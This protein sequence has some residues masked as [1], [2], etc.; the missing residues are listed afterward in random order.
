MKLLL[1][2]MYRG[3]NYCGWQVQENGRTVQGELCRAF[4][5]IV[6]R[7]VK[8]TG[9]SRTDSGV[10]AREYFCTVESED[11]IT[12]PPEKIPLAVNARL[13]RDISVISA[14]KV[15]DA[16]HARYDVK[17]KTYEYIIDN[18]ITH[19]PFLEK[20]S[21]HLPARLDEIKMN[22]AAKLFV[23]EKDFSG[24]MAT[25][26]K[27]RDTVRTVTATGVQRYGNTVIFRVTG[28]GFLYNMVRIMTGTLVEYSLGRRSLDDII[29]A[30]ENGDRKKAG[31]TAPACGL[32]LVNVKY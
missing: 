15:P 27:V 5:E 13:E 14:R 17:T 12:V 26:S 31:I 11:E 3:E 23:G 6:G 16:F 20:R 28:N 32:Y 22:G 19:D 8:V 29:S 10:H 7:K 21:W 24:F 9:C 25:G 4:E 2:L 18:G 1:K 30:L